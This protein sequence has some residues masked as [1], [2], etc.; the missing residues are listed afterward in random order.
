MYRRDP[1]PHP[2]GPLVAAPRG[3]APDAVGEPPQGAGSQFKLI[4][5]LVLTAMVALGGC[6]RGPVITMVNHSTNALSNIVLSGSG[7]S[8]RIDSIAAGSEIRLKVH[9]SGETG[10][11]IEFDADGQ[12]ID[13]GAQGYF[14]AGGGYRVVV[15]VEPDL[16]VSVSSK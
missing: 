3:A 8:N 7:F 12:H 16:K 2:T 9:P 11:R 5:Q 13:S 14:E 10:V 15:T 4:P 1:Q 6:S